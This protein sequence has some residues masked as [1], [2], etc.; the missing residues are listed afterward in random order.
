MAIPVKGTDFRAGDS[1]VR[2]LAFRFGDMFGTE[3]WGPEMKRHQRKT[4]E[5]MLSSEPDRVNTIV[6]LIGAPCLGDPETLELPLETIEAY[7]GAY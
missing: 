3:H 4:K 6:G 1:D 2:C 5:R 7:L